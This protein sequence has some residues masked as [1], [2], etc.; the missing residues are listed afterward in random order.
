MRTYKE[1]TNNILQKAKAEKRRRKKIFGVALS[2]CAAVCVTAIS[3]VLFLPYKVEKPTQIEKYQNSEY[4]TVI[5]TLHSMEGV[6]KQPKYKNNFEKWTA[7]IKDFFSGDLKGGSSSLPTDDVDSAMDFM[8]GAVPEGSAP[9]NGYVETTDNQTAGVIEGDLFKRTNTHIFYLDASSSLIIRIYSIAGKE[10]KLVHALPV[11]FGKEVPY[12]NDAP[13]LYLSSDGNMLTVI[14][15]VGVNFNRYT[16]VVGYDVSNPLSPTEKGRSYL[17]GA[18]QASRLTENELLLF[19]LFN[20]G[21]YDFE[22]LTSFLPHYGDLENLQP[23][24]GED[25]VCPEDG[26]IKRYAVVCSIDPST[27][28]V[29]DCA[30][31]FSY[32]SAD[33][34]VSEEN[35]FLTREGTRTAETFYA[36]TTEITCISYGD[37]ALTCKGTVTVDGEIKDQYSMDEY[38]GVLRV[39]TT[40]RGYVGYGTGMIAREIASSLYCVE[41]STLEIIGKAEKFIKNEDVRSARFQGTKGYICTA[42]EKTDPVFVFDLSDPRN[43]TYTQTQEIKGYSSSLID[44]KDGFLLGVGYGSSGGLKIEAYMEGTEN[45]EIAATFEVEDGWFSEEYK[46]YYIDRERGLIGIAVW[47]R[48]LPNQAR[49]RYYLLSFDGYSFNEVK[50]QEMISSVG[51]LSSVRATIIDGY[52]YLFGSRAENFYVIEV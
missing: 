39:A 38:E 44:F 51:E 52:L 42:V 20:V 45:V 33:A 1:R 18:Y 26:K 11:S 28:A 36:E 27:L 16:M 21:D 7:E 5:K 2:A 41:I 19:N 13:Q 30:A 49:A 32:K 10:S 47:E 3:F 8:A 35:I 43:I 4:Y 37:G 14:C 23:I 24:A 31:L 17:S 6:P 34:Y 50:T 46:S 12:G 48:Y 9:E 25:I 15:S 40:N 22:K 29:S